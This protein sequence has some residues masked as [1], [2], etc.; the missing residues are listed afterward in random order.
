MQDVIGKKLSVAEEI[1]KASG[2]EIKVLNTISD[3]QKEWDSMI[4]VREKLYENIIELTVSNFK[5]EI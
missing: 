1:L 5:T 3:K 4:V 2:Y